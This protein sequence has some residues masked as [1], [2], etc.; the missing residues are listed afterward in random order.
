M[1]APTPEVPPVRVTCSRCHGDGYVARKPPSSG[2][3]Q[4][5]WWD[6]T[7]E[8]FQE[9]TCGRPVA[10]GERY[11]PEHQRQLAALAELP[12]PGGDR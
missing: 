2:E 5:R 3:C 6:M 7:V 10:R 11:C 12:T 8:P 9:W 4:A 1:T